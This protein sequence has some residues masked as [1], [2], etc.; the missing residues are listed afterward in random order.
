MIKLGKGQLSA[1][2]VRTQFGWHL[3]RVDDVRAAQLPPLEA[4]RPQIE[5]NLMEQRLMA[6][7]EDL[8]GR[9][10]IR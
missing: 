10:R 2:P 4:L 6:F 1:E 5:Q 8:R 3:I 9:A 7:Q